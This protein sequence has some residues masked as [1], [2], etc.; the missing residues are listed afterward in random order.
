MS[1]KFKNKYRVASARL[2]GYDYS[3]NGAY[4]I[5]IVT[6]QFEHF[7][8]EIVDDEMILN[9]MG[10]I[11]Q[12]YWNEIP[13]HFPFIRLDEMVVMPNHIHGILWIEN[14]D[15]PV[16]TD[17]AGEYGTEKCKH[18][19][20]T[21]AINRVSTTDTPKK[22]GGITGKN[23]PMFYDNIS[24]VIRWYKGRCSFEIHK[25]NKISVQT[26]LIA[27]LPDFGWQPRFY[28]RI[29]RNENEMNRIRQYIIDNPKMWHRDRN[30]GELWLVVIM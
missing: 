6:Q 23:N 24:R 30:N 18:I 10:E 28:D 3:Q 2:S 16:G 20:C 22:N 19:P 13:R 29:I 25:I 15:V 14:D 21:D 5:T 11:A 1:E 9:E 7:F 8:G 12:K 4:F 17:G 27:S 26:R